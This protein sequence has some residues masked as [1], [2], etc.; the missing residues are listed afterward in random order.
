MTHYILNLIFRCALLQPQQ[1]IKN[2]LITVV[3]QA[4]SKSPP[5]VCPTRIPPS[6]TNHLGWDRLMARPVPRLRCQSDG[7]DSSWPW[8]PRES[9]ALSDR[10]RMSREESI[11]FLSKGSL[12]TFYPGCLLYAALW[13][14]FL[15]N[16]KSLLSFSLCLKM[17]TRL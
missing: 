7:W 11:A 4:R 17:H 5:L 2:S 14:V 15:M 6:D 9:H 8:T 13:L 12:T 16:L 10:Q 3:M 1:Y